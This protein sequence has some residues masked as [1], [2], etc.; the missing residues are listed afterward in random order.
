MGGVMDAIRDPDVREVVIM[1]A[2]QLLKTELLLNTLGFHVHLD[3]CPI[4]VI[5]PTIEMAESFSKERL[6]PMIRDT[7][8]LSGL[9]SDPK[10]RNSDN[11]LRKKSFPGGYVQLAG[12]NSPASLAMRAVRVVLLDE[13][14]RYPLSAGVEGDPIKIVSKRQATFWNRL[15]IMVSS[16]TV[17]GISRIEQA[18]EASDYRKC[19]V[20]CWSCRRKQILTW[21]HVHWS[22]GEPEGAH[23][24]CE[25]CGA[26]WT[27]QQ[28][29]QS[30]SRYEWRKSQ[31]ASVSGRIGFWASE[32]YSPWVT[33]AAMANDW[34]EAQVSDETL[35]TFI[36]T[37]LAESW[38]LR[39]DQLEHGTLYARRELY[40]APIP[41]GSH[42][43]A[44]ADIQDDRIE[45]ELRSWGAHEES[46]SVGYTRLY[47]DPGKPELWNQLDQHLR[48]L[49][50]RV[51]GEPM[52]VSLACIDSGAWT[53]E[54][55]AFCRRRRRVYIPTK[56][57][58]EATRPIAAF[59]RTANRQGVYLTLIGT[60]TA[61]ELL[62]DRLQLMEPG[63]GFVHWPIH[64]DYDG[65]YFE[66][67]TA[68]KR[69]VKR[70]HG[71]SYII[72]EKRRKR[73]EA[74]DLAVLNQ[75]AIRILQTHGSARLASMDE[76]ANILSG[77][78]TTAV[79]PTTASS[80][81]STPSNPN[82]RRISRRPSPG[83]RGLF[84]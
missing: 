64:D 22:K 7:P 56:G 74:L 79:S 17:K 12:A 75:A 23:I 18:L 81:P 73:N 16:P 77:H 61:K 28:R 51:D 52:P 63:P 76:Q 67:L 72:W 11:T 49:R 82:L 70:R 30:L 27:E 3:P 29:L 80:D 57:S 20:P 14:D 84:S 21:S 47:G 48:E 37:S 2:T 43:T 39:G 40:S 69:I 59:P 58:S 65:E 36:N 54:V 26:P 8:V 62:F 34:L 32:L 5:Q 33:P 50:Y 44:A 25:H 45:V 46:W 71:H 19:W 9:F 53:D 68:E 35:K 78:P 6:A 13:V 1:S 66:Q 4:L 55:Y 83:R 60:H 15:S 24:Q 31:K 41:D 10:S 38:E 42:L